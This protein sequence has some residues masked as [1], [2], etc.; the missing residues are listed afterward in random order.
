MVSLYSTVCAFFDP[1]SKESF[2]KKYQSSNFAVN[3]LLQI[4][5]SGISTLVVDSLHSKNERKRQ[6]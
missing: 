6:L 4:K 1:E 5:Q 3:L 2:L